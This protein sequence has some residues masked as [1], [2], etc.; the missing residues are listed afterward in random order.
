MWVAPS[1]GRDDD[2]DRESRALQRVARFRNGCWIPS[3]S[4]SDRTVA[5]RARSRRPSIAAGSTGDMRVT[6]M[7]SGRDHSTHIYYVIILIA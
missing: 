7:G 4:G 3:G 2:G 1:A 6:L 5:A